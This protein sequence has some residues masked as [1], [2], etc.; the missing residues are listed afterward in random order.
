MEA[1]P[2]R[3]RFRV[4]VRTDLPAI[5]GST[6]MIYHSRGRAASAARRGPRRAAL[7]ATA[8]I[9]PL[10][11]LGLARP[12]AA[13]PV[14]YCRDIAPIVQTY[15]QAC[16]RPG[17]IGPFSLMTYDDAKRWSGLI[18]DYTSRR[19]MPPWKAAEGYGEFQDSQ[20]LTDTQ[21]NLIGRWART[22]TLLGDPK[23]LPPPREFNDGWSL[24]VPDIMLDICPGGFPV[25]AK[26]G[27]IF[28]AFVVPNSSDED[29]WLSGMEI[30]PG[31]HDRVH[32][33]LIYLDPS[34][35]S[36]ALDAAA[37]GPGFP[38]SDLFS[39]LSPRVLLD[40][41]LH[42]MTPHCLE[43]GTAWKIPA[44]AYLVVDMHFRTDGQPHTDHSQIGLY[45][46][47]GPID[48]RVRLGVV[49]TEHFEIPANDPAYRVKATSGP[50][51][52]DITVY[53]VYPH[54]HYLGKQ[55]K[56]TAILP[57]GVPLPLL[58]I[59]DW[60]EHWQL[61][62]TFKDPQRVPAQSHIDV[63]A[64]YDNSEDNL[65]NPNSPPIPVHFGGLSTDEMCFFYYR[66]TVD[67][68]HLTQGQPVDNDGLEIKF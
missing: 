15:C 5:G 54:M 42:G 20:R 45:L 39:A 60:D 35:K 65:Q 67:A 56:G 34:G 1:C 14:T 63:E 10:A 32:H 46:A 57:G 53:S 19:I 26:G 41:Y 66:Y 17:G 6:M 29:I 68:E 48:K 49:G 27:D 3:G 12:A 59:P 28:R 8:L 7:W 22:G 23:D 2:Q 61:M 4:I 52:Q 21:I 11:G 24:G 25:P 44:H 62:Y 31:D 36:A 43:P 37:P 38:S 18:S 64:I 30:M 33:A 55:M 16:H 13:Q 47:R 51:P 40:M 58:W 9:A 50:V